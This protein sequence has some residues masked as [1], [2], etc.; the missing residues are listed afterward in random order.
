MDNFQREKEKNKEEGE[1]SP[2]IPSFPQMSMFTSPSNSEVWK[3]NSKS[4]SSSGP[5][6][7]R[8]LY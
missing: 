7:L 8:I 5:E 4:C 3:G 6:R 2:F 1:W